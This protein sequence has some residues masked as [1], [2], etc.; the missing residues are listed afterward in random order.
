MP[1]LPTILIGAIKLYRLT[2]SPWVGQGCR[3]MPTCSVYAEDAIGAHGAARG[4]WLTLRRLLRCHPWGGS[5]YDPAP[6]AHRHD[7]RNSHCHF[8][9]PGGNARIT[10]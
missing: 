4:T 2:L 8:A 6:P 5:G 3:F 9:A 10:R 1:K 7:G